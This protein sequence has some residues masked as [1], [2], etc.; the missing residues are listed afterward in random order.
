MDMDINRYKLAIVSL[1]M[2]TICSCILPLSIYAASRGISVISDLSHQSGKL[3]SYRALIIGIND[4]KDPQ[5]PDLETAL[6]DAQTMAKL[7]RERYGFQVEL[8]KDRKATK[9]AI[10]RAIRKL[11]S[12]TKPDDSVLIYYAGH[13][14]LDRLTNDGWW[15]PADAKGGDPITYLENSTVQT[16]IRSMKASHVLLISDS[17]YSGTLF[18]QARAMPP[19]IG[20]KYYLNLYNEKSR[21]G[22]T[23]GNKTPV[24]DQGSGGH[25]VF[26]YQLLKE[27]RNSG[28]PYIS[29]QELYTRIA[30][31]I[32]NNSEQTPL[33]RPIRNTGDQ[34]GEFVF[35]ASSSAIVEKPSPKAYLSVDSNVSD[36]RVSVD[37][38]YV[39]TTSL[40]D[41]EITSGEHLIRV[42]KF[43]YEPYT[44]KIPFEN[45]R[46][47]DLFV[48]LDPKAPLKSRLYVDIQPEGASIRILNIGPAFHQGMELDA[49]R[50]NLEVSADGYE[51]QKMRVSLT[52]GQ[53]K[54]LDIRLAKTELR[55]EPFE[56]SKGRENATRGW[57][58][59][60]I[61]DISEEL[62]KYYGI[63]EIKGVIVSEVFPGAPADLAGIK[64]KDIILSV[65]GKAIDSAKQ[66]TGMIAATRVGD[67]IQ[68]KINRNG[69]PLMIDV[70][71]AKI[72]AKISS[73]G[74]RKR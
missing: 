47:R 54:T 37:G 12:S 22:M 15:I 30:P 7:L 52:A 53:D 10:Y 42:E 5:I 61:Q 14:D 60:A 17:C 64:P 39:G 36:A 19:V 28:K 46:T 21:W 25:S 45:G 34:G 65:N 71:L 72:P 59:V 56:Q 58:G 69:K 50:Y 48:V 49:G 44:R 63:K 26:A 3:G 27:L 6:N 29:T 16:Y 20:D 66:L 51:T 40:S 74:S 73:R 13:G 67:T 62:A 68:I 32:S 11:A 57:L 2:I 33:C 41:V 31:I 55:K 4:Y 8:L 35:V 23:S 24:S 70:K 38:R 18:G 9:E 1:F 43:G